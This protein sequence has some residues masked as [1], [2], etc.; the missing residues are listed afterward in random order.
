M[1]SDTTTLV[2]L[3]RQPFGDTTLTRLTSFAVALTALTIAAPT[4]ARAGTE[5]FSATISTQV[6][7]SHLDY[8]AE[9][10]LASFDTSLGTLTGVTL[11]YTSNITAE[12]DIYNTYGGSS[13][14]YAGATATVSVNLTGPDGSIVYTTAQAGPFAGAVAAAD[15]SIGLSMAALAGNTATDTSYTE[16]TGDL[17]AYEAPGGADVA[18]IATNTD[19]GSYTGDASSAPDGTMFFSGDA[20]AG[21]TASVT[22]T[23]TT[24][25]H[26]TP[27]PEPAT[28]SI[29]CLGLMGLRAVR[30]RG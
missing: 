23:Y 28:M 21:G 4:L 11:G 30:R 22:Y 15:P 27:V 17:S 8:T 7:I 19:G 5:T 1:R 25:T 2:R 10:Y 13:E 20:T 6:D 16:V 29:F 14:A 24:A 18:F 12:V 9:Y 26:G 3:P